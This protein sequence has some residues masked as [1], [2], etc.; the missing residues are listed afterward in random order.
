MTYIRASV[1]V[2]LSVCSS[3]LHDVDD[4]DGLQHTRIVLN[5]LGFGDARPAHDVVQE[6]LQQALTHGPVY[7]TIHRT[8]RATDETDVIDRPERG[9]R[10]K[11]GV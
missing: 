3:H 7:R 5:Q 2:C 10:E 4:D 9:M 8:P 1:C 6:S 11:R